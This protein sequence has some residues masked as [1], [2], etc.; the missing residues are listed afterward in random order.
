MTAGT[1]EPKVAILGLECELFAGPGGSALTDLM[2]EEHLVKLARGVDFS[3]TSALADV[4]TRGSTY[5]LQKRALKEA[6]LSLELLYLPGDPVFEL[7]FKSY[8]DGDVISVFS[9]DGQGNGL[10]F[11]GSVTEFSQPQPLEDAVLVNA[12]IVPTFST[13]RYP[14]WIT[15]GKEPTA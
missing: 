2:E 5:R 7:L 6:S 9:S 3:L 4:T 14:K 1:E 11:E 10:L 15:D 8:D 13:V 12:T